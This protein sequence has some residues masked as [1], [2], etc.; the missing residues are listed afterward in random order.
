MPDF[1][2]DLRPQ[3]GQAVASPSASAAAASPAAAGAATPA[4]SPAAVPQPTEAQMEVLKQ[5]ADGSVKLDT[6]EPDIQQ[7][8]RAFA[9]RGELD[10]HPLQKKWELWDNNVRTFE[11]NTVEG[12][13]RIFNASKKPCETGKADKFD[14]FFCTAGVQEGKKPQYEHIP[15][16]GFYSMTCLRG[17]QDNADELLRNL[18]LHLI[19]NSSPFAEHFVAVEMKIKN[20]KK[21]GEKIKLEVWIDSSTDEVVTRIGQDMKSIACAPHKPEIKFK[22]FASLKDN[23][24]KAKSKMVF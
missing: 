10:Q 24:E 11:F 23:T 19:G 5:I 21:V 17:Q 2:F 6:V 15:Q 9:E 22:T 8:F 12:F 13:W 7:L 20:D 1:K 4:A 3:A 18:V 14:M 16:G